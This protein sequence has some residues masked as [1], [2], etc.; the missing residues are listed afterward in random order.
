MELRHGVQ[1]GD[2]VLFRGTSW[3]SWLVEWFGWSR[4]SHVGIIVKN[5]RFLNPDLEDGTYLLESSW[6]PTPDAEDQQIKCGVQLH[7]LDEILKECPKGSVQIRH[8]TCE[9]NYEFYETLVKVHKQIH[10]KPYDV[11][12]WDWLSAEYNLWSPLP[13]DARYKQTKSFWCSALVSYLFC[14]WGFLESVNWSLIAP[15]E[16]SEQSK[17]RFLC[18]ISKEKN[19]Y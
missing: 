1:T 13:E 6:N 11:N 9:R 12:P 3:I 16:F 19:L 5:P 2:I 8:L 10:N 4:Y 14:Q 7:L 18:P 15:R 17:L